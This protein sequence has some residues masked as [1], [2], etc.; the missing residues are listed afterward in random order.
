MSLFNKKMGCCTSHTDNNKFQKF[1]IEIYYNTSLNKITYEKSLF[2]LKRLLLKEQTTS[3]QYKKAFS[4]TFLINESSYLYPITQ[5]IITFDSIKNTEKEKND[6]LYKF[7]SSNN[8]FCEVLKKLL[9][10][11]ECL[12]LLNLLPFLNENNKEKILFEI[13]SLVNQEF[14]IDT[15]KYFIEFYIYEILIKS[16][17]RVLK[18][19]TEIDMITS[20]I[21]SLSYMTRKSNSIKGYLINKDL[22]QSGIEEIFIEETYFSEFCCYVYDKFMFAVKIK[23]ARSIDEEVMK[24]KV[25]EDV[26]K[27]FLS[28]Y[29]LLS[30]T[31]LN[32]DFNGFLYLIQ[33]ISQH[34]RN[35]NST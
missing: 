10:S 1:C 30:I 18:S 15:F 12:F 9:D 7:K 32:H 29:N 20:S 14:T 24:I 23:Y 21:S 34:K 6:E 26:V 16:K 27:E 28:I 2:L 4:E 8:S 13:F 31:N 35:N 22:I 25:E 5:N 3:S 11:E 33:N 17:H 19:I